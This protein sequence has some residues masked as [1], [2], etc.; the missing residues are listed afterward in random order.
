MSKLSAILIADKRLGQF[1]THLPKTER[2]KESIFKTFLMFITAKTKNVGTLVL[3]MRKTGLIDF[4]A[5][6]KD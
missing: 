6:V 1:L 5:L 2:R 4:V 3:L